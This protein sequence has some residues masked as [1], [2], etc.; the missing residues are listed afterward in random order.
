[1]SPRT[2]PT[3]A[4]QPELLVEAMERDSI[5]VHV[6]DVLL[7]TFGV[8]AQGDILLRAFQPRVLGAYFGGFRS[9]SL[10]SS[11]KAARRTCSVIM[12]CL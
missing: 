4:K 11:C 5:A 2:L 9:S 6:F 7:Q 12:S 1:V 3:L 8:G 10:R